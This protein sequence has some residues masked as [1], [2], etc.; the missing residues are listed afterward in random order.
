MTIFNQYS[1]QPE[2]VE[3]AQHDGTPNM[4]L[5]NWCEGKLV[6]SETDQW[7]IEFMTRG[8]QVLAYS[9]QWIVKD[10]EGYL[11][12]QSNEQFAD[13]VTGLAE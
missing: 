12:L 5:V 9:G 3:A 7:T 4:E 1:K 13:S 2:I 8:G 11:Q 10:S 6:P